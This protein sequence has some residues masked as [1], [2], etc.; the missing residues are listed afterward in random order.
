MARRPAAAM[1]APRV[2]TLGVRQAQRVNLVPGRPVML[3]TLVLMLARMSGPTLEARHLEKQ[4][5]QP[6]PARLLETLLAKV[7]WDLDLARVQGEQWVTL[8]HLE[9]KR[10]DHSG[11]GAR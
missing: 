6:G 4:A 11:R 3:E 10:D 5:L 2:R 1:R 7:G 8:V 9:T